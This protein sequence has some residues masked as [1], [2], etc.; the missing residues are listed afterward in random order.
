M[1]RAL[2]ALLVLASALP[3][4]AATPSIPAKPKPVVPVQAP[5]EQ[6]SIFLPAPIPL[7]V[8]RPGGDVLQCKATCNR[9]LIFCNASGD[10][11]SCG[12]RWAQCSSACSSS[13][14]PTRFR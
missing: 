8:G 1:R 6:P 10:D 5:I 2:F 9:T 14:Q 7:A 13:Y 3:A 11:D 4:V 12:A